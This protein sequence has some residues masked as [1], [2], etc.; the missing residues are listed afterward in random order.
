[1]GKQVKKSDKTKHKLCNIN[2]VSNS[3]WIIN[4]NT[5]TIDGLEIPK[6][7]MVRKY[8]GERPVLNEDW[9]TATAQEVEG[10]KY[11]KGNFYNLTNV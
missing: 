2:S 1:M 4:Q 7:R 9:R 11:Y 5:Y 8:K 6:G 10:K 3:Y